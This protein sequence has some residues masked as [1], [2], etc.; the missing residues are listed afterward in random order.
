MNKIVYGGQMYASH[1]YLLTSSYILMYCGHWTRTTIFEYMRYATL[2]LRFLWPL[3]S[4][5]P[6]VLAVWKLAYLALKS[7]FAI[8]AGCFGFEAWL[9]N[10]KLPCNFKADKISELTF[11]DE[12]DQIKLSRASTA[13]AGE[14]L[15]KFI[16]QRQC[17]DKISVK[18]N[19]KTT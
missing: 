17:N 11:I 19:V 8:V 9:E 16:T 4:V 1:L 14:K 10:S 7:S 12:P 18:V 5:G 15:D 6:A 13:C 2:R 3:S